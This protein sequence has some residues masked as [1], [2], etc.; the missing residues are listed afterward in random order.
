[1][2][3]ITLKTQTIIDGRLREAGEVIRV[4][5]DFPEDNIK[6]VLQ[7]GEDDMSKHVKEKE[8]AD[9]EKAN[10]GKPPKQN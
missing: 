1:M 6:A 4:D 9:K 2:K 7:T 3:I 10:N 5:D 8:K